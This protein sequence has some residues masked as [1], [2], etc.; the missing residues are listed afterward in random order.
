[1]GES[2]QTVMGLSNQIFTFHPDT[3]KAR[4][5][6]NTNINGLYIYTQDFWF[7]KSLQL[8]FFE[9]NESTAFL[10]YLPHSYYTPAY[11]SF[12]PIKYTF[13]LS[14]IAKR[15][16]RYMICMHDCHYIVDLFKNISHRL[17]KFFKIYQ[18][19]F[20][21]GSYYLNLRLK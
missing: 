10:Y 19:T 8:R 21:T 7:Q 20:I 6:L 3:Q 4:Y 13:K 12:C 18:L 15:T 1:M 14:I 2:Q 5:Y 9:C 16:E 11:H 17:W